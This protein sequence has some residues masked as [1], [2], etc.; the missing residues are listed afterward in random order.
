AMLDDLVKKVAAKGMFVVVA[1]GNSYVDCKNDSP[2]RVIAPNVFVV[3]NMDSYGKFNTTSNF[4]T[5][6]KFAAPGTKVLSTTIGSGYANGNGTS[7]AAPH[8]AGILAL[9][10]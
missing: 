1:A 2:A 7:F 9:T 4:G 3:S 8:V 5:S 6:V 10:G